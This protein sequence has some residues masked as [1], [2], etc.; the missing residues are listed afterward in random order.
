MIRLK[1]WVHRSCFASMRQFKLTWLSGERFIQEGKRDRTSDRHP[2]RP[3]RRARGC[4]D[5]TPRG[6][7]QGVFSK[8]MTSYLKAFTQR[9]RRRTV[10]ASLCSAYSL[11]SHSTGRTKRCK[12]NA[13]GIYYLISIFL[14]KEQKLCAVQESCTLLSG[15]RY[16]W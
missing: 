4:R 8:R 14:K 1:V 3:S 13:R 5:L 15:S 16:R 12:I 6:L 9:N 7:P 10:N 2:E 11:K